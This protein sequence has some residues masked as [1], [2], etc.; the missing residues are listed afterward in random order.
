MTVRK[1]IRQRN[2]PALRLSP[3][4]WEANLAELADASA[5]AS[6]TAHAV[7][8]DPHTAAL[9]RAW[10]RRASHV[11]A[12]P[13]RDDYHGLRIMADGSVRA[14]HIRLRLDTEGGAL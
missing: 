4:A 12:T 14:W 8:G 13:Q 3:S 9:A 6:M 2:A 10:L 11:H 7:C 5:H 1:T